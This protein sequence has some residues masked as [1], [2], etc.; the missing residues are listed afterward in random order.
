[1]WV[2]SISIISTTCTKAIKFYFNWF[3]LTMQYQNSSATVKKFILWFY[4]NY[5]AN[6]TWTDMCKLEYRCLLKH[7]KGTSVYFNKTYRAYHVYRNF[8][9]G[10]MYVSDYRNFWNAERWMSFDYYYYI[11]LHQTILLA[12]GTSFKMGSTLYKKIDHAF[13]TKK[14]KILFCSN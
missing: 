14:V 12:T 7:F 10:Y 9:L 3:C 6:F 1:M 4:M 8:I 2:I 13:L 11:F 5:E